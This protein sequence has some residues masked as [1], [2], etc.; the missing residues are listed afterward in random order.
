MA[1]ALEVESTWALLLHH[2]PC[3]DLGLCF[4][5]FS[6]RGIKN[7]KQKQKQCVLGL[8]EV[9]GPC[10]ANSQQTV[11]ILPQLTDTLMISVSFPRSPLHSPS[12]SFLLPSPITFFYSFFFVYTA[13]SKRI[14]KDHLYLFYHQI[15]IQLHV[16]LS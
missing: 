15:Q 10:L 2:S 11:S 12:L 13:V 8:N 6:Y 1:Q 7:K 5:S 3:D 4:I 9:L 16:Q 14:A